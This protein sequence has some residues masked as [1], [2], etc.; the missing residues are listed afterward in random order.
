MHYTSFIH[1]FSAFTGNL[2]GSI[3]AGGYPILFLTVLLEGVRLLGTA[4]P[5]HVTIVIAGFLA[6]IGILNLCWVIAIAIVAAILGDALGFHLGRK[7]GL[8]LIDRL[9]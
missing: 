3:A 8:S 6:N 5:G 7:C 2:E 9:K 1:A 4:V